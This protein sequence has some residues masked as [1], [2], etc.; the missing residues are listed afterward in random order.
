MLR[1][2]LLLSFLLI[3]MMFSR[4]LKKCNWEFVCNFTVYEEN[5][6]SCPSFVTFKLASKSFKRAELFYWWPQITFF[7]FFL[8]FNYVTFFP[9]LP[10]SSVFVN[11]ILGK[12]SNNMLLISKTVLSVMFFW[13]I[14]KNVFLTLCFDDFIWCDCIMLEWD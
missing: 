4:N 13:L 9:F 2:C 3:I 14:K 6:H 8:V 5:N 12:V 11:P 10:F 7:S 1:D